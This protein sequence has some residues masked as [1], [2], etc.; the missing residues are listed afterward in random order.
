MLSNQLPSRRHISLHQLKVR[1]RDQAWQC[2]SG[3][4]KKE[5]EQERPHLYQVVF[6]FVLFCLFSHHRSNP[7]HTSHQSVSKFENESPS[8][9]MSVKSGRE[10]RKGNRGRPQSVSG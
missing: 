9:E 10:R 8:L 7:T 1:K 4:E 6:A 2:K 5:R 3:R